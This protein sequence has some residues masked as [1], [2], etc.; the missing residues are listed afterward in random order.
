MLTGGFQRARQT[1][2]SD[3]GYNDRAEQVM[4][5]V[6]YWHKADLSGVKG[7]RPLLNSKRTLRSGG[8]G[9]IAHH[10]RFQFEF[11]KSVL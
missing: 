2:Q 3:Q 5:D 9:V 1:G 8:N 10:I 11:I 7:R 4:V 6:R